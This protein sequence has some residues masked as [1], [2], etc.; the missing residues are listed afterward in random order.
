MHFHHFMRMEKSMSA[1]TIND[2]PDLHGR[3]ALITGANSGLGF[4]TAQVLAAKGAHVIMACRNPVKAQ[5]AQTEIQS[6]YPQASLAIAEL[7]LSSLASVQETATQIGAKYPKLDLLFNNAGVMAIPRRETKDGFETQFATN[8]LGH[9][10]LTGLLLPTLLSAAHS[11]V[12]TLTSIVR[13][14]A[15][16]RIE[17]NDLNGQ[18]RYQRWN[19][20][21]QSKLA[22]L[23]FAIELQRRLT[24]I[25]ASTISV[26]AH[27]GYSHTEL[28]LNSA[29]ADQ[30][31]VKHIGHTF[32]QPILGQSASMG[33]LPQLYAALSPDL[34]GGELIGPGGPL[35]VRGYPHVEPLSKREVDSQA[36]ARLWEI[37]IKLTGV[38][39]A[40]LQK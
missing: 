4:V 34:H 5:K 11:R 6:K 40:P 16:G 20:Y 22:N 26:A 36:A 35:G 25:G 14:L 2:I 33:A 7:D 12:I 39:Y 8:Y 17:L 10:A 15:R 29:K 23:L 1:W 27:P 13:S 24:N 3:V 30:S 21:A 38:D 32:F 18:H 37:S 31:L 28:L 9:F 19:A